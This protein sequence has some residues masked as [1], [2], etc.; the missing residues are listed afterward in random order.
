MKINYE[1]LY[2]DISM[3]TLLSLNLHHIGFSF[4]SPVYWFYQLFF[5]VA[6][7]ILCDKIN[8]KNI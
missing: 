5:G 4:E 7:C 3:M 2:V 1:K 6:I 8:D